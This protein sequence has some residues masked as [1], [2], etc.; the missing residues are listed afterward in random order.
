MPQ[1]IRMV[2]LGIRGTG[3]V[4]CEM[5]LCTG[6]GHV[7]FGRKMDGMKRLPMFRFKLIYENGDEDASKN[8]KNRKNY[9]LAIS[10]LVD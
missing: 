5:V 1:A 10:L 7:K 2:L 3:G 8:R 9:L 4:L 6:C